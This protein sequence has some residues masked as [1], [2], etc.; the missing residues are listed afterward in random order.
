ME[1]MK[2]KYVEMWNDIED[3]DKKE[4]ISEIIWK[5]WTKKKVLVKS[6]GKYGR[7]A[8]WIVERFEKYG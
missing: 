1:N 5:I 8:S 3:M 4:G 7:K 6:Y 2:V